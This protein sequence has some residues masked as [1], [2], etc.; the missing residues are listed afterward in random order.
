MDDK[1]LLEVDSMLGHRVDS[2]LRYEDYK[3]VFSNRAGNSVPAKKVMPSAFFVGK[4]TDKG[5]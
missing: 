3:P 1:R 4:F 2:E 5:K